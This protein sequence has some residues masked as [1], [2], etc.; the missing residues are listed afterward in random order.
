MHAWLADDLDDARAR[1]KRWLFAYMHHPPY[2]RGTHDSTAETDLIELHDNLVPLFEA[3]GVDM[4]LTGHS[5][6]YER[7]FL[8]K[9]DAVLQPHASEYTKIGSPAASLS[10]GMSRSQEF[11]FVPNADAT[12]AASRS[13]RS[14]RSSS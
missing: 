12:T 8:A 10:A 3:K 14:S 7:S 9:D 2:S 1:G 5:H 4:V 11:L 6:N 13:G